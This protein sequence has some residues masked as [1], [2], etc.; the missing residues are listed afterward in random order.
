[1]SET[2]TTFIRGSSLPW[3]QLEPG[4]RRQIL[5]HGDDLM[6]VSVEFEKGALGK[7]HHHPHRQVTYVARGT[8]RVT[9]DGRDETLRQGDC[10]YVAAD[11][12][13]GVEALDDGT[14]IDVFTPA[15]EDFL[16]A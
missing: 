11:L 4:V 13:H 12:L 6:M 2:D 16:P 10:F 14:L 9:I 1:L 8:F 5:G 15:R 3:T 7:L